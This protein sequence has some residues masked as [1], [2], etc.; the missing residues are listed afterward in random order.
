[1]RMARWIVPIVFLAVPAALPAQTSE[2]H[3]VIRSRIDGVPLVR[4]EGGPKYDGPLFEVTSDLILGVDEGEPAWQRFVG[5][6]LGIIAPD[7]TMILGDFR[8]LEIFIVSP[9]GELIARRGGPGSGPGEF[10]DL[11][12]LHWVKMGEEFWAE[13]RALSRMTRYSLEGELLESRLFAEEGGDT[14]HGYSLSLA[15]MGEAGFIGS[16]T[17]LSGDIE[18]ITHYYLLDTDLHVTT[19]FLEF[20]DDQYIMDHEGGQEIPFTW[21]NGVSVFPDEKIVVYYPNE[22]CLT[23]YSPAGN[24]V[25]HI[26]RDWRRERIPAEARERVLDAFRRSSSPKFRRRAEQMNLPRRYPC[27]SWAF[28]DDRG[29]I[30]VQRVVNPLGPHGPPSLMLTEKWTH[31]V[32][33]PDGVWLG[34]QELDFRPLCIQ[35][36]YVYRSFEAESGAFRFERLHLRPV[37]PEAAGDI[38][39]LD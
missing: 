38:S 34:T 7:G 19:D 20:S 18:H 21:E 8:S 32:F 16:V 10:R 30:W 4:T 13:D 9:G 31:D 22:G 11:F 26:E 36:D 5:S 15:S 1:M 3:Q 17:T 14:W 29:R 27:F 6:L 24:P 28:T 25:M 33:G 23:L 39:P 37:V 35:G 2:R 12:H